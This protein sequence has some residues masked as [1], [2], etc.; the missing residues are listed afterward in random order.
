[1]SAALLYH[2]FGMKGYE[3][4]STQF[5]EGNVFVW[6]KPRRDTWC[7]SA[8]GSGKVTGH[9]LHVRPIRS[10]P[11]GA[12][13]VWLM[14]RVPRVAC[15]V[16]GKTRRIR[17]DGVRPRRSYTRAFERYVIELSRLTTILGVARH[18]GISWD[19]VKEIQKRHLG[20]HYARPKLKHLRR[21]A[22]DELY[23]G[24]AGYLTLVLDLDSG[25]VV[26]VGHGKG[27]AAL[28][29]FWKRLRASHARIQAVAIDMNWGYVNAVAKHL[30][31]AAIVFDRFHIVKLFNEKL[32]DLR[33][34]LHREATNKL[35]KAVLKGTRWLLL[36][37]P[38][39]LDD[40]RQERQRLEEA[41]RINAPLATAYYLK[42]DLRQLW[43]QGTK[44]AAKRFLQSW[45]DR[46]E[47][48]GIRI[49][50]QFAK[51]LATFRS[52]ILAW[53]DHPISTGPLEGTNNKIRTM[54]RQA[55][56]YRDLDF[57]VLKTYA[58][59]ETRYA[60]IG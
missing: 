33:R 51:T 52:G 12:R 17:I 27:A 34:E 11:I 54:Q 25:R 2:A 18:L 39:H 24:R 47:C 3:Y 32:S 42:E 37:N 1:M 41:L 9:G 50:Q 20:R 44:S 28:G 35:H 38:D 13:A 31:N 60:L 8:C 10:L 36:K 21:L 29:P 6:V 5:V 16:C 55:Y 48:S 19:V 4:E 14:V 53:Y 58:L 56:G 26:F 30:P 45:M 49:V 15:A 22:I 7:C 23:I 57:F 43:Q 59:H 46:A 40:R